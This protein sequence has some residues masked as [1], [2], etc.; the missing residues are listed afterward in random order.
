MKILVINGPNLNLL[1]K[2]NPEQY[3]ALTLEEINLILTNKFPSHSFTFVQ[4][5]HEGKIIDSIQS[6]EANGFSGIIINPGG[7]SHSSVA[8]RDALEIIKIPKI[9]VHLSNLAKREEF[10]QQSITATAV[11]GYLSGFGEKGYLAAVFLLEEMIN[12]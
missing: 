7:Y 12:P 1:G 3:G 5:N 11:N 4:S 6:S 10:R 9:E 8:I 2:R